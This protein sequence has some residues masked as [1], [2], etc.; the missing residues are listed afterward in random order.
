M[1]QCKTDTNVSVLKHFGME[2]KKENIELLL[3]NLREL[4]NSISQIKE[5][6]SFSFTFFRQSFKQMQ[7]MMRLLHELEFLHVEDMKKQMEKLVLLLSENDSQT[8]SH[9]DTTAKEEVKVEVEIEEK[10]ERVEKELQ[11]IFSTEPYRNIYAQGISLPD[12]VNP[13]S[14]EPKETDNE[15]IETEKISTKTSFNTS[16]VH[17]T[18]GSQT[19]KGLSLNDRFL[20]QRELFN[21]SRDEMNNM[22]QKLK[23]F[24]DFTNAEQYL[25]EN[26][27]WDLENEVVVSF[28]QVI[29]ADFDKHTT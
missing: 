10:E 16:V 5:T 27:S 29:K 3:S 17:E 11:E 6:E 1:L 2:T 26:T 15:T 21:N 24:D 13:R 22:M 25:K 28:I 19:K 23:E 9:T 20:F 8:N 14:T 4:E 12:Y 18:V 7:E